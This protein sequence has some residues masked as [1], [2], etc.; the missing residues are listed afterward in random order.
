MAGWHSYRYCV[1]DG[2]L[3]CSGLLTFYRYFIPNGMWGIA[4]WHSYRYCVPDGTRGYTGLM[5]FYRYF[6]PNG[7]CGMAGWHR[8][9]YCV[10]DGTRGY[11]GLLPFYRY[12]IP[13]G[14]WGMS[15]W[16]RLC[17]RCVPD[18]KMTLWGCDAN[19]MSRRDKIWVEKGIPPETP[20][21]RRDIILT[22]GTTEMPFVIRYHR[23]VGVAHSTNPA[24]QNHPGNHQHSFRVHHLQT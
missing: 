14:M 22:V 23:M 12:F 13:N 20:M 19:K 10:P 7:M 6:I 5:P 3:G 8:F 15:G 4:G 17:Q 16:L 9:R 11:T 1:P 24:H 21:S 2:T 18:G